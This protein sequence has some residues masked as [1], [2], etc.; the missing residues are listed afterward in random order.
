MDCCSKFSPQI[1]VRYH[2]ESW[3]QLSLTRLFGHPASEYRAVL[4]VLTYDFIPEAPTIED[5]RIDITPGSKIELHDYLPEMELSMLTIHPNLEVHVRDF[6]DADYLLGD[7]DRLAFVQHRP[8][9]DPPESIEYVGAWGILLLVIGRDDDEDTDF[10]IVS[11]EEGMAELQQ[12]VEEHYASDED[13]KG[14]EMDIE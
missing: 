11:T 6:M 2:T 4:A 1:L 10:Q 12:D 8:D 9:L 7:D 3:H 13:D 14:D 5:C